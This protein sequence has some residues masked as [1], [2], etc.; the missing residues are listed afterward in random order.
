MARLEILNLTIAAAAVVTIGC[1]A[2]VDARKNREIKLLAAAN[3]EMRAAT[4]AYAV[5]LKTEE[6][7][8]HN[9][10]EKRSDDHDSK[11]Q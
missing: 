8:A 3:I 9:K 4:M 7:I 2:I 11:N 5:R 1:S 10:A 6:F